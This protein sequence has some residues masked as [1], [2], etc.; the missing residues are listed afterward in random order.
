[1]V[2]EILGHICFAGVVISFVTMYVIPKIRSREEGET[3]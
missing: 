2:K 1:M 3:H